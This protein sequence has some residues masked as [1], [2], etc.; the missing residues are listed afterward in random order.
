VNCLLVKD[1]NI[2]AGAGRSPIIENFSEIY[3]SGGVFLSRDDGENWIPADSGLEIPPGPFRAPYLPIMS[4]AANG[5]TLYA[6][7][8]SG[9]SSYT[10][11]P[12]IYRSTNN[13]AMWTYLGLQWSVSNIAFIGTIIF[14]ESDNVGGVSWSTDNGNTWKGSNPGYVEGLV[15]VGSQLFAGCSVPGGVILSIDSGKTWTHVD[16]G[17]TS[18]NSIGVGSL[19]VIG[20][21]LFAGT[22]SGIWR[23]PLTEMITAVHSFS[24]AVPDKFILEQ[25]YPNPFNPSTAIKYQ[26]PIK[27]FVTLKVYNILGGELET[28]VNAYLPAGYYSAKFNGSKYPSGVYFYNLSTNG[29]SV[30]KKMALIK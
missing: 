13:G 3:D 4:L 26:L 25:N 12:G 2:F 23:R 5:S 6:G 16:S 7:T 28:L 17:L 11:N 29:Y 18:L 19:A 14:T 9:M 30:V 21:Y 10:P 1:S 8:T 15:S 22:T 27:S 24:S 20:K